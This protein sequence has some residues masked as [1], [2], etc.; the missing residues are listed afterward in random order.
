MCLLLV[1][2][3]PTTNNSIQR[4]SGFGLCPHRMFYDRT[5]LV[6]YFANGPL[7]NPNFAVKGCHPKVSN[8]VFISCQNIH[9]LPKYLL[10]VVIVIARLSFL[11]SNIVRCIYSRGTPR[12]HPVIFPHIESPVESILR[13]PAIDWEANEKWDRETQ[14]MKKTI[15]ANMEWEKKSNWKNSKRKKT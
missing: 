10:A 4:I 2:K 7:H 6:F 8:T 9:F 1:I 12:Y 13:M 11:D 3:L 14:V 5:C 15:E